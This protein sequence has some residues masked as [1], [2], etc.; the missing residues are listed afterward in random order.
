MSPVF[1]RSPWALT[2]LSLLNERPMHPYEM[3]R[4]IRH[5]AK[6]EHIDLKPGSLY[7]T[8]EQ[9]E[10]SG[11][12]EQSERS[13]E[14]RFPERTVYC[15]TDNGRDELEE[16]LREMLSAL[17]KDLP[18]FLAALTFLPSLTPPDVLSQL[19][20]RA[21]RLEMAIAALEA[22]R[23]GMETQLPRLFFLE[24]EYACALRH[25][26]LEHVRSLIADLRSGRLTWDQD[27]LRRRWGGCVDTPISAL[28]VVSGTE[29]EVG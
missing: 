2:I 8:I 1:A 20:K 23:K 3:R 21:V 7:R 28:E 22:A 15:I 17:Q 5:R 4:L 9:L 29:E 6:D 18:Q 10:R 25:A 27:E 19:E 24:E 26:E 11:M 12:V 14:G 13:R 16:W